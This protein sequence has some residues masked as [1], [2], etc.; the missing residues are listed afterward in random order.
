MIARRSD[1]FFPIRAKFSGSTA[2]VAPSAAAERSQR[3]ARVR[4][5]ATSSPEF[6]WIAE[7]RSVF[8]GSSFGASR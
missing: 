7:M 4:L 1:S 5:A 8:I 3:R 2:S 6:I